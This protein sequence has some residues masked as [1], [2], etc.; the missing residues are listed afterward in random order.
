MPITAKDSTTS[1]TATGEEFLERDP[2][3]V[4]DAS[5][6]AATVTFAITTYVVSDASNVAATV[7]FSIIATVVVADAS[8]VAA[9]VA[10]A[11]ADPPATSTPWASEAAPTVGTWASESAPS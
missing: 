7:A 3:I 5:N 2:V 6:V 9:T 8:N 1:A 4:A 11:V 10:F